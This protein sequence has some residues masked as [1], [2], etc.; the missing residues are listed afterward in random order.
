MPPVLTERDT[1]QPGIEELCYLIAVNQAPPISDKSPL[2]RLP[3]LFGKGLIMGAADV[4]PGVSGGT[5]ALIL[6]IY[7]EL[8]T[9]LKAFSSPDFLRALVTLRWLEAF[10]LVGGPFL[11]SVALGIATAILSLARVL[12]WLLINQ[13]MLIYSFFFGLILASVV[14]V[15]RRI[16]RPAPLYW[17]LFGLSAA[18][19]FVLVGLT[20]ATTPET[21]TF[22]LFSG[23]LAICA[24]ILPGISGAFILL[25]LGKYDFMFAALSNFDLVVIG[26]F[27][28][29]AVI[30]LLSFARLLDYLY[31]RNHDATIAVLAGFM[32][33]SL[34]RVWPFQFESQG[35]IHN[36]W[37]DLLINNQLNYQILLAILFFAVGLL[38]VMVLERVGRTSHS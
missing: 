32:L 8:V 3:Q 37:P 27:L 24:M 21:P 14:L 15:L 28:M 29:G 12:R 10:R 23:A 30:G 19:T 31:Q 17:L 2:K 36:V 22:I 18:F 11:L 9:N 16:Q 6:G 1:F 25:L 13:Q 35:A 5:M 33:G 38:L 34:R 7:Q 20:P 4:I 26:L